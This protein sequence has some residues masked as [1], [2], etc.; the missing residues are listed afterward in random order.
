MTREMSEDE[1]KFVD[2][3]DYEDD[4]EDL[5]EGEVNLFASMPWINQIIGSVM[6]AQLHRYR[7]PNQCRQCGV[8]MPEEKPAPE[9]FCSAECRKEWH[10]LLD[11]RIAQGKHDLR[12]RGF[13]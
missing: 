7:E 2:E 9:R 8:I 12:T 5:E 4:E 6:E 3:E 10:A 13:D 11:L 1:W